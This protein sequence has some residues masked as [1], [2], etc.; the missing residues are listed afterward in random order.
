VRIRNYR[1]EDLPTLLYIERLAREADGREPLSETAFTSWLTDPAVDALA[2]AF[3]ITDDDDE[4]N[5]WGQAGTLEGIEG[6]IVGYTVVSLLR[7]PQ[8]Y[9]LRCQG[10]I[11]PQFRRQHAGRALLICALNRAR[12]I[13]AEFEFEA[14]RDGLPI[15]F[16]ALLPAKDPAAVSLAAKCDMVLVDNAVAPGL[17]L[18]GCEL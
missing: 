3:V 17:C 4:L 10:A 5:T 16:E 11:H 6:E 14:E 9:H 12:I 1:Q 2:N 15:Y 7:E 13:A 18:Y 8:S